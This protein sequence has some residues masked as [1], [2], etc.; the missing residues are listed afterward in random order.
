MDR[1]QIEREMTEVK[2]DYMNLQHDIEKLEVTGHAKQVE[3][4]E[5]R[6]GRMEERLSELRS[7]LSALK[8]KA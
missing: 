1:R 4:A 8:T 3:D 7:M 5:A 6:L 2:Y